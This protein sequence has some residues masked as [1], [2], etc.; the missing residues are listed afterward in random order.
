MKEIT[1]SD[2]INIANKPISFQQLLTHNF[3]MIFLNEINLALKE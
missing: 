3:I 2:N 1:L